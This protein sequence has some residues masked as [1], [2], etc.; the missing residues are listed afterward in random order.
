[1]CVRVSIVGAVVGSGVESFMRMDSSVCMLLVLGASVNEHAGVCIVVR[2]LWMGLWVLAA[3]WVGCVWR[4]GS[5]N[6]GTLGETEVVLV[7]VE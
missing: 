5:V 2:M 4:V 7:P 3:G 6:V 1:M